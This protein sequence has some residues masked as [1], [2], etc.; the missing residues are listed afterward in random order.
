M[1]VD[2]PTIPP[3]AVELYR[4]SVEHPS[5]TTE[6]AL[7]RLQV[8]EARLTELVDLL[9]DLRLLRPSQD[10]HR[11]FSTSGPESAAVELLNEDRRRLLEEQL[12][13][14]RLRDEILA[15]Q[16]TYFKAR[17][18]RRSSEAF[19]VIEDVHLVR[20]LLSDQA[21]RTEQ[22]LCIAHPGGG[23]SEG[24]LSRSIA[25]DRI[26]LERGVVMRSVL[27]H[28]TR[29]HTPTKEYVNDITKYGAQVRTIPVVPRRMIIFDRKVAF[30][31]KEGGEVTQGAVL[32]REPSVV[33]NFLASFELMWQ[34]GRQFPV[35]TAD[36]RT[37]ATE[38]I[39]QTILEYLATG[40]KDEVISRKLGIS[41]RSCRRHI[42]EIMS[43]L[44][45]E[46]R[47][48]AGVL[49]HQRGLV[50]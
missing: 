17:Q 6:D 35:D 19:D 42:A 31:P 27:Q 10:S 16:P 8:S 36:K 25:L 5:W 3:E 37:E 23:M 33:D 28:A 11:E 44:K 43:D 4:L 1:D 49:A 47:F 18:T 46:S 22:E 24:G 40:T 50:T 12:R 9:V 29:H 34:N 13:M 38:D 41:V 48:Q 30:I 2:K 45:A 7:E 21:Q 14:E 32:L 20:L 39:R 15:L 26:M